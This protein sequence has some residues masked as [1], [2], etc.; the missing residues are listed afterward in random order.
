MYSAS[1]FSKYICNVIKYTSE[2]KYMKEKKR[3]AFATAI[4]CIRSDPN[5]A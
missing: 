4:K 3:M 5:S 2:I 1:I